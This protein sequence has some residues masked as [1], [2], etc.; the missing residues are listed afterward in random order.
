M[1]NS[2]ETYE[3]YI[4]SLPTR[5]PL[6]ASSTLVF[7]RRGRYIAVVRGEVKFQSNIRLR[8]YEE[9]VALP[10]IEITSYSYEVWQGEEKL[11]WYDPQPHP[12]NPTLASTHPHHKHT[13]PDIK[14]HRLPAPG[15]SFTRPNLPLLIKEIEDELAQNFN[16]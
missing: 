10:T 3:T 4:Y 2:F 5:Y 7:V 6:V 14:H 9:L 12:N 8:I 16:V 13:P 15:F 11:Y 1:F